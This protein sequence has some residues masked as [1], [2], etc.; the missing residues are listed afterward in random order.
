MFILLDL[1]LCQRPVETLQWKLRTIW[2][3]NLVDW[4]L[5]IGVPHQNPFLPFP[6]TWHVQEKWEMYTEFWYGNV[7]ESNHFEDIRIRGTKTIKCYK[8]RGGVLD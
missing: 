6:C 3:Q 5:S 7:K 4:C 1:T 8:T 2:F